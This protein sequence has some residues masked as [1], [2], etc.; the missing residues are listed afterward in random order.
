MPKTTSMGAQAPAPQPGHTP[1]RPR[2]LAP[3][4]A[5]KKGKRAWWWGAAVL[6]VVVGAVV[7]W[8][9]QAFTPAAGRTPSGPSF[10]TTKASAGTLERSIR[11]SGATGAELFTTMRAPQM[12]GSRRGRG[13]GEFTTVLQWVAP[14]GS[15]IKKGDPVAEFDR[16][17]ILN[18]MED[19]KASVDQHGRNVTRLKANLMMS[20]AAHNQLVV[21][22]RGQME[23]AKLDLQK[24]PVVS[25]N[26]GE[27]YKLNYEEA[28]LHYENVLGR[29]GH[30]DISE[31]AAVRRAELDYQ[32]AQLEYTRAERHVN[33]LLVQAPIDGMVVMLT[34][35]RNRERVQ[36]EAGDQISAGQPYMQIVDL[37]N[38]IVNASVNQVDA[39]SVRLGMKARIQFDAF[40]E[41]DLPAEVVAVGTLAT[42]TGWRG[43]YVRSVPLQLKLERTDPRVIPDLSVS[44]DLLVNRLEDATLVPREAVFGAGGEHFAFV[45]AGSGWEKRPVEVLMENNTEVAVGS[46][47]NPGDVLAAELPPAQA[48]SH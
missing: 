46:G 42:Q 12:R 2:A 28:K 9:R 5:K 29:T 16:L 3:R 17:Y 25:A 32:Q 24:I 15:F 47:V 34:M 18:R 45:R 27:R 39:Q 20:R 31:G 23:Q 35:H 43:A 38:M 21:R 14:S 30:V 40:P 13:G 26:I 19:F 37:R 22:A 10:R 41:L 11:V 4:K 33:N 6:L 44:A 1:L 36:I 7:L 48:D 8:Q